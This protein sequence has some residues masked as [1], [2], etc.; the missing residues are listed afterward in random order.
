[1]KSDDNLGAVT[2]TGGWDAPQLAAVVLSDI[3]ASPTP[4]HAVRHMTTLL[5]Q[6]GYMQLTE[7][8]RWDCDA[9]E[10]YFVVRDGSLIIYQAGN[11]ALTE[12]GLRIVGA[13]TDSPCLKIKPQPDSDGNGYL[14]L[15]IEVYG[16]ALFAPWFDRDLSV[17]GIVYFRDKQGG[18]HSE[19][20][21]LTRPIAVIPSLA[22]HLDREANSN[23]TINPQEELQPILMRQLGQS[24][25][26]SALLCE[27]LARHNAAHADA[28]ILSYELALYDTQP[29]AI[30][31]LEKEF[32]CSARIDNLLSCFV[33]LRVMLENLADRPRV[34]AFFNH[35]EVGSAS[36][37]G[38]QGS[39]LQAFIERLSPEFARVIDK[40][41]M[42]SID[43]A[44]GVHP[45]YAAKHDKNHAPLINSGPVIKHNANQ[46]YAT[47]AETAAQFIDM[48]LR[49]DI[50]FQQFAMRADLACGSTIGPI[51]A[52]RLGM[53]TLDIGVPQWAMHSV[54]E[55]AGVTDCVSLYRAVHAFLSE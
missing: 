20:I 27:E 13:H 2:G 26:F 43:N 11:A 16:G 24:K 1:M 28:T 46:R 5:K 34:A 53:R 3:A 37:S 31:G 18:M 8:G 45:N 55:T 9:G 33:A 12:Q 32:M 40:S 4:Y 42:L 35:E 48:C 23:R 10:N 29:G 36:R 21:D 50:P 41:W 6:R 22:I 25:R 7:A 52:T 49:H 30:V 54:R 47:S 51:T 39:F 14:K 15:G 44:H 38:A 17:A 19:L